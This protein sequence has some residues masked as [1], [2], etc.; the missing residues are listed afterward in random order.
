MPNDLKNE[1]PEPVV[2]PIPEPEPAPEPIPEPEAKKPFSQLNKTELCE[3]AQSLGIDTVKET[4]TNAVIRTHIRKATAKNARHGVRKQEMHAEAK[5]V[6][7]AKQDA[8][9][10]RLQAQMVK[11]RMVNGLVTVRQAMED[12]EVEKA[13]VE[14]FKGGITK[15]GVDNFLKTL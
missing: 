11:E 1:A 5:E 12:P 6:R 13:L 4:M 9:V 7:L 8:R 14:A 10:V 3:M 15:E 2:D